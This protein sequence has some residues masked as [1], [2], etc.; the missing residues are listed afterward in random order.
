MS[1]QG[2]FIMIPPPD[3]ERRSA[4]HPS[5]RDPGDIEPNWPYFVSLCGEEGFR[6]AEEYGRGEHARLMETMTRSLGLLR[7]RKIEPGL[8]LLRAAEAGLEEIEETSPIYFHVLRR[9]YFGALA[10]YYYCLED[11]PN[12]Q[13]ALDDAHGAVQRAIELRRFLLPFAGHCHDFMI[14][15]IR[16]ERNQRRWDAMRSTAE[17]A[18]Q[19][20]AGQRPFCVLG[21]GTPIDIFAIQSFYR[22][23]APFTAEESEALRSVLDDEVRLRVFRLN[24][25]EIYAMPG[26]VIPYRPL[27]EAQTGAPS[28]SGK[29]PSGRA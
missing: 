1:S 4:L 17:T 18:R 5:L 16:I 11:F 15:R 2:P 10:Y 7:R 28:S 20:A 24:L 29:L 6:W 21:D 12:A 3:R 25:A 23:L 22:S 13:Q 19:M 8:E 14:Q 9:W 26:F 27:H